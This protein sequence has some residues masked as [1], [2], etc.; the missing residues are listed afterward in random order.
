MFIEI[1]AGDDATGV[2][3]TD[4]NRNL[5]L[6]ASHADFIKSVAELHNAHW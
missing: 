1:F 2:K 6:F 4:I 3:W 5:K